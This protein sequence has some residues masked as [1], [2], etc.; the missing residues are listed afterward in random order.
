MTIMTILSHRFFRPGNCGRAS[1]LSFLACIMLGSAAHASDVT[2]FKSGRDTLHA[3]LF[4]PDTGK[5]PWPAVIVIHEWWGVND[6]VRDEAK[7]FTK[8]GYAA[9]VIDLYR[10]RSA[11]DTD[12][13]HE[14]SR[15]LPEDRAI[16]D[17][18]AA[19]RYLRSRRDIRREAIGSVGYC[20]GGGYSLALATAEPNLAACAVYYGRLITEEARLRKIKAPVIGF[21]GEDD[22]GISPSSV[23]EFEARMKRLKKKIIVEIYPGAGHAFANATRSSYR[24]GAAGDAR[25]KL[26]EFFGKYLPARKRSIPK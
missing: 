7:S 17:L 5:A 19:F 16:G 21:F 9:L 2:T 22:R 20:L 23:R 3:E 13:A 18:R 8:L 12:E 6:Q 14:L 10:G 11:R 26:E 15:G 24:P 4:L 1:V 25:K